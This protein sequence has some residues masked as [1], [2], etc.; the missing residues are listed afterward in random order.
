MPI[1]A[2]HQL[3][4]A[5]GNLPS[6]NEVNSFVGEFQLLLVLHNNTNQRLML[7]LTPLYF[8]SSS[9]H[10]FVSSLRDETWTEHCNGLISFKKQFRKGE[11]AFSVAGHNFFANIRLEVARFT[12]HPRYG[13]A[14]A[15]LWYKA[16]S[17]VRYSFGPAFQKQLGIECAEGSAKSQAVVD[18]SPPSSCFEQS[19]YLLH[20]ACMDNCFQAAAPSL[21]LGRRSAIDAVLVPASI[22]HMRICERSMSSHTGLA[23][24]RRQYVGVGTPLNPKSYESSI[25]VCDME[26]KATFF[27][28]SGLRYHQLES[29][30][31]LSPRASF[32]REVWKPDIS[33]LRLLQMNDGEMSLRGRLEGYAGV[34]SS[35]TE[36]SQGSSSPKELGPDTIT[37]DQAVSLIHYKFAALRVA[38]ITFA[39]SIAQSVW[40]DHI[41]ESESMNKRSH[42]VFVSDDANGVLNAEELYKDQRDCIFLHA[43]LSKS[44]NGLDIGEAGFHLIIIKLVGNKR[45]LHIGLTDSSSTQVLLSKAG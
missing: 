16:M 9:W 44:E 32:A 14:P 34:S 5:V 24:S 1:E 27:T 41:G 7:S 36:H 22:G 30:R 33:C 35:R 17:D 45:H 12:E 15:K 18:L 2:I 4:H 8:E 28:V 21:W 29:V 6:Y 26:F 13:Y 19:L 37:F 38:E 31:G 3:E 42:F 20:P 40:P 11:E 25:E 23:Y 39:P 10:C 43:D